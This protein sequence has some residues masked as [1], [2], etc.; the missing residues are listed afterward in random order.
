[1]RF[2]LIDK[3][4]ELVLGESVT[5]IKCITATDEVLHD[6]FPGIPIMP[7]PSRLSNAT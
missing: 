6:H 3:V 4:T 2:I 7:L 1:M 5:G